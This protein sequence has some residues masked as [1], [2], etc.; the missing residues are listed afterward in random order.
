MTILNGRTIDDA[1]G[2][3]AVA[4]LSPIRIPLGVLLLTLMGREVS[5]EAADALLNSSRVGLASIAFTLVVFVV[6]S[7][8]F[9]DRR[10]D[11]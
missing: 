1:A 7:L 11:A 2:C 6:G 4:G 5:D 9:P 10:R 8:L 3:S